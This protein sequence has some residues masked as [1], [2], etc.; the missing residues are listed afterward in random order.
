[1]KYT[2]LTNICE[3]NLTPGD[4][5]RYYAIEDV[6]DDPIHDAT[7]VKCKGFGYLVKKSLD[8]R[9][10][11]T[12]STLVLKNPMTKRVWRIN[13]VRWVVEYAK[14]QPPY[15]GADIRH[16]FLTHKMFKDI[17]LEYNRQKGEK[18]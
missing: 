4:Y 5:I 2:K 15:Q 14:H 18:N 7:D 11:L 3:D 12:R 13:P 8:G 6:R 16:L 10:P 1:M 9:K 17:Q